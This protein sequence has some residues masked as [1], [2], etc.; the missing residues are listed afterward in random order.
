MV[1]YTFEFSDHA[2]KRCIQ[3]NIDTSRLRRQLLNIP[4]DEVKNNLNRWDIPGTNL[5]VV[6]QD[7]NFKRVIVTVSFR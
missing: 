1:R 5:F 2:K 4:Y 7:R 3:R 6:F